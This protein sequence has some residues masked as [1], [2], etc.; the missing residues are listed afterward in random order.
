[1]EII[2]DNP[3]CFA[4]NISQKIASLEVTPVPR[5]WLGHYV[6][7]TGN[8]DAGD[9]WGLTVRRITEAQ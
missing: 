3:V 4:G 9:T 1:M 5:K 7:V 2:L 6:V 8:M